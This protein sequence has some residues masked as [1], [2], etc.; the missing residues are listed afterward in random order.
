[1]GTP[2]MLGQAKMVV[3]MTASHPKLQAVVL[4][5]AAQAKLAQL[6]KRQAEVVRGR[7]VHCPRK[8]AGAPSAKEGPCSVHLVPMR[9]V[10][11][12]QVSQLPFHGRHAGAVQTSPR[13]QVELARAFRTEEP[14]GLC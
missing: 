13:S 12:A 3:D 2:W 4:P 10:E 9:Q 7:L 14:W 1:M 8:Q 11:V 6:P 5:S